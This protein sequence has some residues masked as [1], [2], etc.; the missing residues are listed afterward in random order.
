MSE[1]PDHEIKWQEGTTRVA[2]RGRSLLRN[3]LLN[4]GVAFSPE[5]RDALGLRGLLPNMQLSIDEQVALEMEHLRAKGTDLEKFIGLAALQDRNETLFYRVLVE[6]MAELMPIVYTPTVGQACQQYSHILRQTRGVWITPDDIERIPEILRNVGHRDIR[7][8]VVTD[9]ERILGLG[10]Q[11]AGGMGI[12]VGKIALYCGGAGIHPINTLPVSL[13]VGTDNPDL[14]DDPYY[15][16]YRHRR[17]RGEPYERV[18]EAFVEAVRA[19]FPRALVQW[20]DFHKNIAFMVL[21]RYRHRLACFNDDIQGTAGVALAGLYGGLRITKGKLSE[22]R[23][24][25]A[26][27]GAAG[28]GIGRLVREGMREETPDEAQIHRNQVF[29]DSRGLVH[30][31][32]HIA[33]PHK[34]EFAMTQAELKEYGF[35]GDG[36]HDLLEVIK[37]VKPTILLGTTARAGTFTEDIVREMAKHCERPIIY[38]F[39]NPNS[40]A[41]CTPAE[42]IK[43]T[44]GRALV[45]TGS[46]F[47]PVK[48]NGKTHVIGQGNNV[49]IFPGVG[50]GAI[51]SEANE[52]PES[53]FMV[54]AKTLANCIS[55]DRLAVN[56]LYPDQSSLREISAKIAGNVIR[57]AKKLNIGRMIP[58]EEIDDLVKSSMWYPQYTNL[59]PW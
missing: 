30:D 3:S 6:N 17:L 49:F 51:L 48:Y 35:E 40:K 53:F 46:P 10:D 11:G 22:Q 52:V 41:E 42:A 57:Q 12:P 36:P 43:W 26:G 33:D 19:V 9:N 2:R 15:L 7:L 23:I 18:V 54:A 24:V 1:T 56:A 16:G 50:L 31:G 13:D 38:A 55:D 5:E 14:L 25:Y 29:L 44:D 32:Q 21:D 20:E 45:A 39:S 59:V 8:I 58:D 47:D 37:R 34:R 4:K 28:V 27:A